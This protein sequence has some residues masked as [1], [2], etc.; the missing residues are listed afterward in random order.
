MNRKVN[1]IKVKNIDVNVFFSP[2]DVVKN[3]LRTRYAIEFLS[4]WELIN[5]P[6]FKGVEFDPLLKATGRNAFTMRNRNNFINCMS[7][8]W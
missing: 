6:D 8:L 2:K 1:I 4:V 5:N 3:W 7:L